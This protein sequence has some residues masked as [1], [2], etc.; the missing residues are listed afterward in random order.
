M[1]V[2]PVILVLAGVNGA[3]KSS[4]GGARLRKAGLDWYNPDS[5]ARALVRELGCSQGEANGAA[6]NFGRDRLE[7][8]IKQGKNFAF[9]TTLGAS[10]I[11]AMLKAAS[12]THD[13]K[14]WFCGL[15]SVELHLDRVAQR[16]AR[17]GH[18]IAEAKIRERWENSRLN[19]VELIPFVATLHLY[20]NSASALPG[21]QIPPPK[22]LLHIQEGKLVFPGK[23]DAAALSAIPDWAKPIIQA[24]LE[25]VKGV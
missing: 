4:I 2:R 20:D 19:L 3:G 18:D 7:A 13:V 23:N 14:L 17:G 21:E 8:A 22:L 15:N 5:Y 10:T 25:L 9:E 1:A 16:V 6:W 12:A 11:P 24:A